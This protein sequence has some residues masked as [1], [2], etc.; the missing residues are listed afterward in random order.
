[1]LKSENLYIT[2]NSQPVPEQ[3]ISAK[4]RKR[5]VLFDNSTHDY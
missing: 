5:E 4:I 1:M 3:R 2:N